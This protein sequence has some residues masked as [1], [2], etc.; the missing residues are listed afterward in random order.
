M[1]PLAG[2][3][4]VAVC[5]L[6]DVRFPVVNWPRGSHESRSTNKPPSDSPIS[7]VMEPITHPMKA[8]IAS[9]AIKIENSLCLSVD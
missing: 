4:G 6:C 7:V 9:T 2:L 8:N 1:V 5:L 3:L